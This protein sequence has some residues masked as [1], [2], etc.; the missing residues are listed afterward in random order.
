MKS[1]IDLVRN[2]YDLFIE[3]KERTIALDILN[4]KNHELSLSEDCGTGKIVLSV[5]TYDIFTD[6]VYLY[7]DIVELSKLGYTYIDT[8]IEFTSINFSTFFFNL[9]NDRLSYFYRRLDK[10]LSNSTNMNVSLYAFLNISVSKTLIKSLKLLYFSYNNVEY[11]LGYNASY[12]AISKTMRI[13][14][15]FS[16]DIIVNLKVT[17]GSYSN[18]KLYIGE[19]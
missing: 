16:Y 12:K 3:T 17:D 7:L 8:D 19:L 1:T 10:V 14:D 11:S 2:I 15:G 6:D 4:D 18:E 5:Y 9:D 13:L